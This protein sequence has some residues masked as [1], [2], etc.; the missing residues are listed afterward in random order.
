MQIEVLTVAAAAADA[1]PPCAPPPFF[2]LSIN[3]G[4]LLMPK[5]SPEILRPRSRLHTH[6]DIYTYTPTGSE[7]VE[8]AQMPVLSDVVNPHR[9]DSFQQEPVHKKQ[10]AY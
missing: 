9:S 8:K 4:A 5:L 10:V 6:T 1:P 3:R 2:F 7:E